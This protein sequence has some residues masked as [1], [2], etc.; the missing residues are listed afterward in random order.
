MRTV[1]I[2]S[3]F[4]Y[5]SDGNLKLLEIN[6]ALGWDL[7]SKIEDDVNCIDLTEFDTFIKSNNFTHIHYVG[8]LGYLNI[9]LTQY[10]SDNSI[11]YEYHVVGQESITVPYIEDNNETLI[12]RS[13]Y[14]TTA[15][16]DDTY[17]RDK[18]GFMNLTQNQS[19]GSK[20]AYKDDSGNLIN[21]ITEIKDNGIH[22]NFIL[23]S[24]YPGY[25]IH[26][27]P[28][29]F[30]VSNQTELDTVINDNVTNEYFLMEFYI[31][32]EKSY[33]GHL[34]IIRS[35][36][37]LLPPNLEAIPIGEY[38]RL[39][40]N[41]LVDNVTYNSTTLQVDDF[42]RN[43]YVSVVYNEWE[44]KLLDTDLVELADGTFKTPIELQDGDLL[45][46]IDIPNP[47]GTDISNYQANFNI[48]YDT[49]VSGTTY[50]TNQMLSKKRINVFAFIETITF[51][52]GSTWSDTEGSS[53]LIN[54]NNDISFIRLM[55][56][57]SGDIM[58]LLDASSDTINFVSKTI[59]STTLT[60][61]VF[62]GWE[63]SVQNA[64]LFLTKNPNSTT[65]QSYVSIEHNANFC[66]APACVPCSSPCASCPKTIKYCVGTGTCSTF[67]CL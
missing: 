49:L 41:I 35:L 21:T 17:C 14:D 39:N 64:H 51:E 59:Q 44:P 38:T 25:D 62:S 10:C 13:S 66:P 60:K 55:E 3:D 42:F 47:N 15:L 29:L 7:A 40:P 2:G 37:L 4:M 30:K 56:V 53:Y 22:P 31:N 52:D 45:K 18:V 63:I 28:K 57:K 26:T 58:I 9:K 5:D 1:L 65:N 16:V 20:F 67:K 32:S 33:D 6:T 36:N 48:T 11:T 34:K 19:F 12:I 27:F 50:S 23:K 24:R 46:T 54:R 43:S 61:E 8:E